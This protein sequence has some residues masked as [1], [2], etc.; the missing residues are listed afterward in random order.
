MRLWGAIP[1][2]AIVAGA[3]AVSPSANAENIVDKIIDQFKNEVKDELNE[4]K[5][6]DRD[7]DGA[8]HYKH[9]VIIYQENHSFD[10][11]YGHWGDVGRDRI[12]G[13]SD[14]DPSHT[15]QVRQDNQTVFGCLLQND[16]NLTSP[17]PLATS[18]TDTTGSVAILSAFK[19]KPF[20]INAFI[21]TS[22]TTCPKPL[23]TFAAHG[24]LNGTGAP[25]GCTEDIV[26]RFYSE[27][28]QINGGRQNRYMVGS[29]A[30]GLVMGYYD[31]KKLPIYTYLHSRGAPNYVIADSFFQAAFG[32]SFL[33][34]Q[35]FVAAAAP[36]FAGAPNDGSANDLHS[37]V[38]AN[39]MPTSTPL[40]TPTSTV[41]DA[42]LTAKCNQAGLP[43]GLAC[44]DYAVNTTQ[45]FY[46]PY[47]PGTAEAR[48]LPPLKTPNIGDRLSAKN[49]DWA[50]YSGG[51]S[52]ANGD[53]GASGWTNGTGT[54]CADPNHLSTAVFPNCPDVTFQFHH[55]ALNYFAAYA[56]GTKARKDHLKDEAEFI[57]AAKN[58]TLKQVSFI[59]PI[60]E[61]NE[62]PGYTSESEGSQHL[63]DLIKAI[64]EG[65]DGK[66]T[67][68]IITYDEF[69]GQWD[70][71]P[72]PPHNRR[73][74]DARAADQWG[75]GTRIP[76][77]LISK[78]FDRS[79][80]AHEDFDTTSILKLLEKRFDLEPLVTRPV[81][82]LAVALKAAEGHGHGGH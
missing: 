42:Q 53:I 36:Q 66:D 12:N 37:I 79:G 28:Y 70:H 73:G 71:V 23:G 81:R 52:N 55:Q 61:E 76:A 7:H 2:L 65:P 82:N 78:R 13:T 8:K 18:C 57:Q 16:V 5:H 74:A 62:H 39:G 20:E 27:Q 26:H 3:A 47:S 22:A 60:G 68:I 11:L 44:G 40:Y 59:K 1:A 19:N 17:S 69:G 46:Q 43:A 67:L 33:N 63:V 77:I 72:P 6:G 9:I 25:G 4:L 56:P 38:D 50:W 24:F 45:P 30:S 75:P 48:R 49:I 64:T 34:H 29:D 21:P 14:A 31:T 41:K 54:T 35:F 58:G 15:L 80:V 32:G 10:N 51:W